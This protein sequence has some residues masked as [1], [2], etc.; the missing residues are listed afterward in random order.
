ML[1]IM[2]EQNPSKERLETLGV[3]GWPILSCEVSDFTWS[4][5]QREVC[6]LLEG[7]VV[8]TPDDGAPVELSAGDLVV[9][10][11]G[12]NCRWEVAQA[13]RKHYRLG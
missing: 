4:Y 12:M 8:V 3:F 11:A 6:Y 10:P 7:R 2:I 1:P 5:D 13:V 9:F